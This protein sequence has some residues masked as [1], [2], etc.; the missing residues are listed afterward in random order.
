MRMSSAVSIPYWKTPCLHLQ[1]LSAAHTLPAAGEPLSC[2]CHFVFVVL[3]LLFFSPSP[4]FT[5]VEPFPF[6]FLFSF[7]VTS[8]VF[9]SPQP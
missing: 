1:P 2:L 7:L 6:L 3:L 5:C 8:F 9:S 4:V